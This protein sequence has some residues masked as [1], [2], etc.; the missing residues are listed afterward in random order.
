[1]SLHSKIPIASP[2]TDTTGL[3]STDTHTRSR[4]VS[5]EASDSY[6]LSLWDVA[7]FSSTFPPLNILTN[8]TRWL[9]PSRSDGMP[10]LVVLASYVT[11]L[12]L[13]NSIFSRVYAHFR[14]HY[15]VVV[16]VYFIFCLC[17]RAGIQF[18]WWFYAQSDFILSE[19]VL[20]SFYSEW[21]IQQQ[22]QHQP[23]S[24][25]EPNAFLYI[26]FLFFLFLIHATASKMFIQFCNAIRTH[27]PT[28]IHLVTD[29]KHTQ[30]IYLKLFESLFG[31][32]F[33]FFDADFRE[34]RFWAPA[35]CYT[36]DLR[37]PLNKSTRARLTE[38]FFFYS[39]FVCVFRFYVCTWGSRNFNWIITFLLHCHYKVHIKW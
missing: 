39:E 38:F 30:N 9:F 34:I 2:F 11:F 29:C 1:M 12:S 23:P 7:I 28:M 21:Y 27:A 33:S 37:F 13:L 8:Y 17:S 4:S 10:S 24:R 5:F 26:F 3:S 14:H 20:F 31:F 32:S 25:K 19:V 36:L 22:Q 16:L 15:R 18:E 35:E 6:T